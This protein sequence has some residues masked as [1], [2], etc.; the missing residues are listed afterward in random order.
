M[1][2]NYNHSP[3]DPTSTI[4]LRDGKREFERMRWW[5]MYLPF[6]ASPALRAPARAM[7]A[8]WA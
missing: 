3:T 7:P 5:F 2:P 1:Q 6:E 4:L 8:R